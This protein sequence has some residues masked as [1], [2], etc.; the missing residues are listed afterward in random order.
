MRGRMWRQCKG[1]CLANKYVENEILIYKIII[2]MNINDNQWKIPQKI[3]F[4]NRSI[5][6]KFV[7][8]T[9]NKNTVENN[10]YQI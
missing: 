5:S 8:N 7:C 2:N 3:L 4:D 1:L 10:Y 6:Q 9:V